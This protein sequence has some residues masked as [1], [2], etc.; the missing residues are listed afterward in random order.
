MPIRTTMSHPLDR[1]G[2]GAL[3][4]RPA[5]LAEGDARAVRLMR[6]YGV[7][8]AAADAST[9]SL[10]ALTR[11]IPE[12]DTFWLVETDPAL[13]P[14][15]VI[16]KQA[17]CHQMVADALTSAEPP[18]FEIVPLGE[19]DAPEMFARGGVTKP[20]PYNERTHRLGDFVGVKRDG[21]LVAMAGERMR[22][23]GFTEVSGVC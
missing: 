20:G 6:D 1:P 23:A 3:T 22:P 5:A 21:R 15:A 7:F 13:P 18:S 9:E 12:G 11:L 8:A 19:A 4:T 17:L 14:G 16:R 2:W 10:S